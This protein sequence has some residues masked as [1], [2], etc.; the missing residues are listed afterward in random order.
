MKCAN[1][2]IETKE[3]AIAKRNA[4]ELQKDIEAVAIYQQ[5]CIYTINFCD[6]FIDE[7]LTEKAEACEPIL[8]EITGDIITDRINNKYF[9]PSME[10]GDPISINTLKE[11]LEQHCLICKFEKRPYSYKRGMG[12][13]FGTNDVL[14]IYA[15]K[16]PECVK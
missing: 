6:T 12:T 7:K 14:I 5:R 9:V 13:V 3:K 11:Y 10:I 16:E 15:P 1:E 8:I 2:L 4:E